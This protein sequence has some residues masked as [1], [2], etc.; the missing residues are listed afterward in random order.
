MAKTKK[1]K[2]AIK[3]TDLPTIV[4]QET[5]QTKVQVISDEQENQSVIEPN[6]VLV[7]PAVE[8]SP[9][10]E[11][12]VLTDLPDTEPVTD[13]IA[14][15]KD[16]FDA[17]HEKKLAKV[18]LETKQPTRYGHGKEKLADMIEE[19]ESRHY[20]PSLTGNPTGHKNEWPR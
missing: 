8:E 7:D 18:H 2:A 17:K 12:A 16:D 20:P 3:P 1:D 15:T 4:D 14:E 6:T 11:G 10:K 9:V 19:P 13:P 5:Q